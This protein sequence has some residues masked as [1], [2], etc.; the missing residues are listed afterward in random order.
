VA[1]ATSLKSLVATAAGQFTAAEAMRDDSKSATRK[2]YDAMTAM[3]GPTR[4]L[5]ATIKAYAETSNNPNV[6][7]LS[8]VEPPAPPT[9]ATAPTIPFDVT[10]FVSPTGEATVTWNADRSGASTGVFFLVERKRSAEA[11]FGLIG[12]TAEKAF[13]DLDPR[14]GTGTVQYRVKAQRGGLTSSWSVPIAFTITSGGGGGG[15]TVTSVAPGE[16]VQLAA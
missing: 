7:N 6:Y 13:V 8:N 3:S 5:I 2:F 1:Q 9:P 16:G 15:F 10:G 14:L 11:G 4:D 12:G